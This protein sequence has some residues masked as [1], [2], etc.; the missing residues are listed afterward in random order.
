MASQII[1]KRH[2]LENV[3]VAQRRQMRPAIAC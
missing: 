3:K 2:K 1:T